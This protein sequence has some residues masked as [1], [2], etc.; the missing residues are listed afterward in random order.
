MWQIVITGVI[1]VLAGLYLTR[2]FLKKWRAFREGRAA[3]CACDSG[4][5]TLQ[6]HRMGADSGSSREQTSADQE[7]KTR[8]GV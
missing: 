5:S 1:L 8:P 7:Q 3:C 2:T 4:P 6:D